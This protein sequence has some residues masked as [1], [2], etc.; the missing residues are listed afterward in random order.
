MPSDN[1][2]LRPDLIVHLPGGKQIVVDAK[3]PL[4]AFL[5]AQECTDDE[6][7]AV[8]LQAHG[9]RCVITWIGLGTKPIGTS[10]RIHRR[11]L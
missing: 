9:G 7:R 2:R 1:G 3:T 11:W 6:R 5:D 10:C 4:D 8:R